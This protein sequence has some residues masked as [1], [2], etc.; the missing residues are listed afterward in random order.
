MNYTVTFSSIKAVIKYLFSSRLI[1]VLYII[2]ASI[3][4]TGCSCWLVVMSLS[5]TVSLLPTHFCS[6]VHLDSN[7]CTCTRP[8]TS[9]PML[10]S[11]HVHTSTLPYLNKGANC[12]QGPDVF[13][14]MISPVMNSGIFK[15]HSS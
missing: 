14:V 6:V 4:L 1:M 15:V 12:R 13:S 8:S 9:V 2:F 3:T 5:L 11:T 7:W 10:S